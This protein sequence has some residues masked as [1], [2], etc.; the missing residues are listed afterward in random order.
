MRMVGTSR[1]SAPNSASRFANFPAWPVRRVTT[2]RFPNS[3]RF[4]N[5][6]NF[7]RS[8]TTSPTMVSAGGEIFFSAASFAIVAS[9]PE[10]D[11]CLPSVPH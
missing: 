11:F 10:T 4:S 8:F 3:G 2:I 9:V 5:Q 6:F 1:T 7:P